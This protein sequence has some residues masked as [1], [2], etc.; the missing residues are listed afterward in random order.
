MPKQRLIARRRLDVYSRHLCSRMA[1]RLAPTE[2]KSSQR[3]LLSKS[4]HTSGSVQASVNDLRQTFSLSQQERVMVLLFC[5]LLL[6]GL[7]VS[8]A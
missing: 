6:I 5:A 8:L 3:S 2:M 7:F 1:R 4:L